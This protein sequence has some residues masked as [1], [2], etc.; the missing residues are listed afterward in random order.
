MGSQTPR[1]RKDALKK[2]FPSSPWLIKTF[3]T[4]LQE[5]LSRKP[6]PLFWRRKAGTIFSRLHLLYPD[7]LTRPWLPSTQSAT[8]WWQQMDQ[9]SCIWLPSL[10]GQ[11]R[12]MCMGCIR[13]QTVLLLPLLDSG[14]PSLG[15][16]VE[17]KLRHH[18]INILRRDMW[19]ST[20][21][22]RKAS[23]SWLDSPQDVV[24]HELEGSEEHA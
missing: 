17:A 1:S 20:L 3:E 23:G 9:R 5:V 11:G 14:S 21:S 24:Y 15:A 12:S 22:S 8:P 19:Q 7:T 13:R 16:M 2:A 18:E 4:G 6:W 10:T